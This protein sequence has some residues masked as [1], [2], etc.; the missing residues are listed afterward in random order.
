MQIEVCASAAAAASRAAELMAEHAANA[1]ADR[2]VAA[3]A[4]SGG[5]TP[6]RMLVELAAARIDWRKVHVFQVDERLV[7][8]DDDRRNMKTI[9][10]A[11]ARSGIPP[12]RLHAMPVDS[13]W[14]QLA[15]EEYE[16][17]L[18]AIAG[19]PPVLDAVHVGLGDDGH[20]ASL[21]PGDE[22]VDAASQ[23]ALSGV[24]GGVRRMTMTL[25]VINRARA[26]VWLVAGASKRTIVKRLLAPGANLVANRVRADDSV[27]ILDRDAWVD[28]R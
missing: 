5:T 8:K 10:A 9:R 17:E 15:M 13:G 7:A 18:C 23:I 14:P 24:H 28:P 11:F 3:I 22:A 16:R 20:T 2:N 1:V 27:L 21:F 12:D 6:A 25:A 19:T 26:R 4:L